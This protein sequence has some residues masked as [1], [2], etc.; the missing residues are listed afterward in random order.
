MLKCFRDR[1]TRSPDG[2]IR[3]LYIADPC[4]TFLL[5]QLARSIFPIAF[6]WYRL[7][8]D[9]GYM[10]GATRNKRHPLHQTPRAGAPL[11]PLPRPSLRSPDL[12]IRCLHHHSRSL[13]VISWLTYFKHFLAISSYHTC[14]LGW[15]KIFQCLRIYPNIKKM[16]LTAMPLMGCFSLRFSY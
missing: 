3:S 5:E 11:Y 2:E 15:V 16:W 7:Y 10:K 14:D 9:N 8:A 13:T 6:S 1:E 4:N 12:Q